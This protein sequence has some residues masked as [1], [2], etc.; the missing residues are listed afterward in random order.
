MQFAAI[1]YERFRFR[2][3]VLNRL[4]VVSDPVWSCIQVKPT[5]ALREIPLRRSFDEAPREGLAAEVAH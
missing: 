1:F 5:L 3:I 4:D 2:K